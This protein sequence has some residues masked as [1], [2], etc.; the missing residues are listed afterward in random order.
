MQDF[1]LHWSIFIL[2]YCYFNLSKGSIFFLRLG[3]RLI[4]Q[5]SIEKKKLDLLFVYSII[6]NP[7]KKLEQHTVSMCTSD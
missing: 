7:D 6:K 5:S 3:A 4:S 2:Q 1:K